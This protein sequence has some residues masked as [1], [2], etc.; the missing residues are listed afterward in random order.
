MRLEQFLKTVVPEP[1]VLAAIRAEA[2]RKKTN[3]LKLSQINREIAAFRRS[4]CLN[5]F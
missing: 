2:R 4:K 5:S 3:R 1:Q